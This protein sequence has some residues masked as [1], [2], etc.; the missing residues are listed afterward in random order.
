MVLYMTHMS[1]TA[2]CRKRAHRA[3]HSLN[4][5]ARCMC[6]LHTC[7]MVPKVMFSLVAGCIVRPSSS[8]C[9]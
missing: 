1:Q 8:A 5:R 6:G 3:R 4:V 2:A 7:G 9:E